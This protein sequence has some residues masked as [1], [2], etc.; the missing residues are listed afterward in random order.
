MRLLPAALAV[1]ALCPGIVLAQTSSPPPAP[2]AA[3]ATG[4]DP[5]I[6]LEDAESPR[7]LDWVKGENDRS[8]SVLEADPHYAPLHQA[9]LKI[10]DA[11]D[12]I[13]TPAFRAGAIYNLWQDM[14]QVQG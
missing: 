13:P 9:A 1:L 10:V 4:D 12:R 14:D 2:P 3:T 6:W 5:F 7:A 11:T 8:L